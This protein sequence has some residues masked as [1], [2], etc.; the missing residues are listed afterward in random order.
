MD[1]DSLRRNLLEEIP[2]LIRP[3]SN[4]TTR[5]IQNSCGGAI[6]QMEEATP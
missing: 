6:E 3:L 5:F 1:G 2:G 4:G